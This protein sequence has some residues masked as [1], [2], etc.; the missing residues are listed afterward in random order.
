MKILNHDKI[1][2]ITMTDK[3][4]QLTTSPTEIVDGAFCQVTG[5]THKGQSGTIRDINTSKTGHVTITVVQENGVRFKTL[6]S[7]V[8][9][10]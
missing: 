3:E 6:A 1:L 8:K 5:G 4:K 9:I 2:K 7:N 10:V